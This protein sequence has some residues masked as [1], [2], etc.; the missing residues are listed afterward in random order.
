[1]VV[2]VQQPSVGC[3]AIFLVEKACI[4]HLLVLIY[5]SFYPDPANPFPI[6]FHTLLWC[7]TISETYNVYIGL[8]TFPDEWIVY[9][10]VSQSL[11]WSSYRHQGFYESR[12]ICVYWGYSTVSSGSQSETD[13]HQQLCYQHN[14]AKGQM[15]FEGIIFDLRELV[16]WV[17]T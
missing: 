10:K 13:K 12:R 8:I 17:G 11:K 6:P 7:H 4:A 16:Q 5:A 1:M 3:T 15:I 14:K 2:V 9:Y